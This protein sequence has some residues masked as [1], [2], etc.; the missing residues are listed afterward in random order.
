MNLEHLLHD[1][2]NRRQ[3]IEFSSLDRLEQAL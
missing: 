2:A 3:G 1:L